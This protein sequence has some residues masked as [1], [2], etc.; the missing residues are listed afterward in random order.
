MFVQMG[1]M[2]KK[3]ADVVRHNLS[4]P[5]YSKSYVNRHAVP[6]RDG[7]RIWA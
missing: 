7:I 4:W 6:E 1:R 5:M 2:K 3:D